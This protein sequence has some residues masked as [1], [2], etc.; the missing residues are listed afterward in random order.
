M[1]HD[2]QKLSPSEKAAQLPHPGA[3]SVSSEHVFNQGFQSLIQPVSQRCQ[4]TFHTSNNQKSHASP[5]L[6]FLIDT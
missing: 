4:Q 1:L 6:Q 3:A 5:F 2:R